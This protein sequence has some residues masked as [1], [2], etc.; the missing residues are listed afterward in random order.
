MDFTFPCPKLSDTAKSENRWF[1]N[2]ILPTMSLIMPE[3]QH[4]YPLKHNSDL[5]ICFQKLCYH[6]VQRQN[7][8]NMTG[9]EPPLGHV[10]EQTLASTLLCCKVRPEKKIPQEKISLGSTNVA[11]MGIIRTMSC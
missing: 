6:M 5:L 9:Y 2:E 8:N 3:C 4:W 7:R 11:Y 10:C 1:Q